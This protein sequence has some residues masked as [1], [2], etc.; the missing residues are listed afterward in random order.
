MPKELVVEPREEKGKQAVKRLRASGKIPA[1]LYGHTF[2]SLPLTIDE[3]SLRSILRSEG[4]LHGLFELKIEG[5]EDGEHTVVFK[6][7]QLDPIKDHVLHVD[8]QKIRKGEELTADVS[9]HFTGDPVGVKAG[10]ILQHYLREVT[11]QCLPK[12]LPDFIEVDISHLDIK[13]N[14]RISNLIVLEGVK[15]VN[16]PE[17][18]VA[19]VTPKRVRDVASLIAEEELTEEKLAELVEMGEITAE[20][21]AEVAEEREFGVAEA[22]AEEAPEEAPVEEEPPE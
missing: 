16:S 3:R 15:Y 19:A 20:Q 5:V 22:E 21:A 8:F 17:E 18:I 6:E 10:G 7:V 2:D 13:D 11:V 9:L 4:G 12:D 1:I 14:L